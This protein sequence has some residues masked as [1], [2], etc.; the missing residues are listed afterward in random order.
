[1]A[2]GQYQKHSYRRGGGGWEL[3]VVGKAMSTLKTVK[4]HCAIFGATYH[5]KQLNPWP[6][7]SARGVVK[8]SQLSA[9]LGDK[10]PFKDHLSSS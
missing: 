2:I 10:E 5:T 3:Q 9:C 7:S 6:N 1:M 4:W 8:Y